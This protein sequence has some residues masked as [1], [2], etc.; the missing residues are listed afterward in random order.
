[1]IDFLLVPPDAIKSG[2]GNT[3]FY[4]G[5]QPHGLSTLPAS[6]EFTLVY[7]PSQDVGWEVVHYRVLQIDK[8]YFVVY[9]RDLSSP[10]I[11]HFEKLL[12][13]APQS[14]SDGPF[15]NQ[16]NPFYGLSLNWGT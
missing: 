8:T 15:N 4:Y 5:V 9:R 7:S 10:E 12:R 2:F 11:Q 6:S 1:M 16:E 14:P 13:S 3:I